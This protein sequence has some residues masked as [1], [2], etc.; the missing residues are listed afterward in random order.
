M[1][2]FISFS[3]NISGIHPIDTARIKLHNSYVQ[4]T[5]ITLC[6][7]TAKSGLKSSITNWKSTRTAKYNTSCIK[8]TLRI[9][10]GCKAPIIGSTS[11]VS[12]KYN[13]RINHQCFGFIIISCNCKLYNI[14]FDCIIT[15]HFFFTFF[16]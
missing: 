1:G 6:N 9:I 15:I 13:R 2:L 16:F 8:I 4:G 7:A 5:N 10:R 11:C 14:S 3:P 12:K